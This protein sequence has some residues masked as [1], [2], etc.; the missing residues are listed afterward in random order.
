MRWDDSGAP[1]GHRLCLSILDDVTTRCVS[2]RRPRCSAGE[3]R[4][5]G[6]M[7]GLGRGN[8]VRSA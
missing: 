3:G 4:G 5:R 6:M 7:M 8:T 2:H 1:R